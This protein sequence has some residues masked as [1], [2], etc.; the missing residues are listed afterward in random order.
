MQQH[1][2]EIIDQYGD[3][4]LRIAYT[5]VRDERI[6]QEILQDVLFHTTG[7]KV[8]LGRCFS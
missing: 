8:S 1:L 2:K 4:L 3:Y 6:A 5:Y 7:N